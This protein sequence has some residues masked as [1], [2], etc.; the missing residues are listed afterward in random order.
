MAFCDYH[1]CDNCGERKTF[2]DAH[3]NMTFVDGVWRYDH[4][5][6]GTD[7]P[8]YPG[9]RLFALCSECEKTHQIV[10]Q[11]K[12]PRPPTDEALRVRTNYCIACKES[13]DRLAT[14]QARGD[15][16]A[17]YAR[18][19]DGCALGVWLNAGD[20]M[21]PPQPKCTCGLTEALTEWRKGC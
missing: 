1:A 21:E 15:R 13:A 14:L 12:D 17:R 16:L 10:I 2:Y 3:M 7:Y 20:H 18:H 19:D 6:G 8:A 5:S 9:Y 11:P 4:A